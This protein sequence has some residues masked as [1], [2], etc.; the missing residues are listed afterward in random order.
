MAAALG[1]A[2]DHVLDL[3]ASLN[4]LAPD[5]AALACLLG[6]WSGTGQGHYPTVEPFE[7]HETVVFGHVG[8]PSLSYRQATVN[9]GNDMPSH[10]ETGYLRGFGDSR[11]ETSAVIPSGISPFGLATSTST[12]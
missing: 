9:L 6:T 7:Y 12:R 1:L 10:A 3:S 2:A 8:K 5:V 4:P 11:I